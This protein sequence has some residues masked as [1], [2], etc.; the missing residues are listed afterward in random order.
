SDVSKASFPDNVR[1]LSVRN[2][3]L[4]AGFIQRI[5]KLSRLS[6][7]R[8]AGVNLEDENLKPLQDLSKL[9][10]LELKNCRGLDSRSV[11]VIGN[12]DNLE[13]L[14]LSDSFANDEALFSILQLRKLGRLELGGCVLS[15]Q[16]LEQLKKLP[17][18]QLL[19]LGPLANPNTNLVEYIK[20]LNIQTLGL[21]DPDDVRLKSFSSLRISSFK[22]TYKNKSFTDDTLL[23]LT[24]ITSMKEL[25]VI[26]RQAPSKKGIDRFRML[27][28]DCEMVL[29]DHSRTR[30]LSEFEL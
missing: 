14:V 29:K 15:Q 25:Q 9:K 8:L 3:Q 26:G 21:T 17:R 27:R 28:P 22:L 16:F 10:Y 1:F 20:R 24:P 11:R 12:L 19:K 5:S 6:H 30:S 23:S 4:S 18:L 2:C 7:L 13:C